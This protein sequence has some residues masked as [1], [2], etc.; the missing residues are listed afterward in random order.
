MA[1]RLEEQSTPPGAR[2]VERYVEGGWV[3]GGQRHTGAVLLLPDGV[4]PV[5]GLTLDALQP[6]LAAEPRPEV[7]LLGTGPTMKR[8]D[9][10]LIDA[11]RAADVAPEFMDSRAAARTYNVLVNEERRVAAVLLPL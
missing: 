10:A 11:L 9:R 6:L 1:P 7:V 5:A 4:V 8:P 2:L 3:I